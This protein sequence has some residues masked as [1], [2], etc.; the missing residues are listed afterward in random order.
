MPKRKPSTRKTRAPRVR[1]DLSYLHEKTGQAISAALLAED[2]NSIAHVFEY[3]N[4]G[5]ES[6]ER[7]ERSPLLQDSD[8]RDAIDRIKRISLPTEEDERAP[9]AAERGTYQIRAERITEKEK[10]ELGRAMWDLYVYVGSFG[11]EP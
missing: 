5:I 10:H 4:R 2:S 8:I 1:G 9:G 3:L 6:E 7:N 11:R